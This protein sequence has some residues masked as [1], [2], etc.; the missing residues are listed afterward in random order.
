[1]TQETTMQHDTPTERAT[2]RQA[3]TL[4][5]ASAPQPSVPRRQLAGLGL[6]LALLAAAGGAIAQDRYPSKPVRIIVQIGR[7]HV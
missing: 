5:S 7:A 2:A 6:G 4:R 1:M 3:G